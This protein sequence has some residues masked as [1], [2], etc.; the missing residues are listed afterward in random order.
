MTSLRAKLL[1]LAMFACLLVVARAPCSPAQAPAADA[2]AGAQAAP[3]E[4]APADQAPAADAPPRLYEQEPYD[5]VV[6]RETDDDGNNI[7]LRV[8]PLDLPKRIVPKF[9]KRNAKLTLRLVDKP[10]ETYEVA[11]KDVQLDKLRLF[12]QIVLEEANRIVDAGRFDEAYDWFDWLEAN[13]P[14]TPGLKASIER[15]LDKDAREWLAKG[16]EDSALALWKEVHRRNPQHPGLSE[17]LGEVIGGKV[18]RAVEAK[19]YA[20]ARGLLASLRKMYAEH[21][22]VV[23][24]E[25]KLADQ[26][27]VVA[28]QAKEQFDAGEYRKAYTTVVQAVSVWPQLPEAQKVMADVQAK[29]PLVNVGVTMPA[30]RVP[31]NRLD[32]WPS[33]RSDRLLNRRLM[34]FVGYGSQGGKYICPFGELQ[35]KDLDRQLSIKLKPNARWSDGKSLLTGYDVS[36]T[37]LAMAD[38]RHPSYRPDWADL[39]ASVAVNQVYQVDLQLRWGHVRSEAILEADLISWQAGSAHRES[40][41]EE[42][43]PT[44]GPYLM[45]AQADPETR[46]VASPSYFLA[47]EKQP[48]EIVER[49]YPNSRAAVMA[50]RRGEID[51]LDRVYPWDFERVRLEKDLVL[52]P[53]G[54]PSVHCLLPNMSRPFPAHRSLRR[55]LSYSINRQAILDQVLLKGETIPGSKVVSGPFPMGE[56]AEDAFGYAYNADVQSRPYDPF[57]AVTLVTVGLRDLQLKA[58]GEAVAPGKEPPLPPL[59]LAHPPHELARVACRAIQ[60]HLQALKLTVELR[61]VLPQT[62][63]TGANDYDFLYAELAMWE[64]VV[65]AGRLLGPGGL[66]GSP[67][68]YLDLALRQL[69]H[70]DGWKTSREKLLEIHK[71]A[72]EDAAVIPLW[73]MTDYFAYHRHVSGIGTRPVSLYQNVEQWKVAP[74]SPPEPR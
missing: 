40:T 58:G 43:S 20:A 67:S 42:A 33:R 32:D 2:A 9:P 36:R 30:G 49:H 14:A 44:I 37:V 28:R 12:E 69:A 57:L 64:P 50:L 29:Y 56:S 52:V 65:D 26:A 71:L 17:S 73:Q 53:Y 6:L 1:P 24:W 3:A 25:K 48:K 7:V 8:E 22:V 18:D 31:S 15:Y 62:L 11:W 72:F 55:A 21:E 74:W 46:F 51:V 38:P 23:R 60:A 27:R 61:E 45:E 68:P 66:V 70:A 39:F 4:Q 5:E 10:G 41:S 59:I 13:H 35:K 47:G 63:S 54:T 34:E 19:Q 16:K